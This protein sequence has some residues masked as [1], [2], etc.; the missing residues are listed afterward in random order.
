VRTFI[1]ENAGVSIED[2][3][4]FVRIKVT[5]KL[6]DEVEYEVTPKLT[7]KDLQATAGIEL[8]NVTPANSDSAL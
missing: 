3:G 7:A 2:Q 5:T 4:H 6:G 8:K 1:Y